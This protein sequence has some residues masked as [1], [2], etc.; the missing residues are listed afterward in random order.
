MRT[1]NHE[2]VWTADGADVGAGQPV[3][4]DLGATAQALI[5]RQRHATINNKYMFTI[6]NFG[7]ELEQDER[8]QRF[9]RVLRPDPASRRAQGHPGSSVLHEGFEGGDWRPGGMQPTY[10]SIDKATG[11]AESPTRAMAVGS[12]SADEYWASTNIPEQDRFRWRPATGSQA[13]ASRWTTR[14]IFSAP[15]RQSP[16]EEVVTATTER[17]VFA[18]P[19]RGRHDLRL[20][21]PSI[22]IHKFN[23]M[24]DWGWFYFITQP[25]GWLIDNDLQN[26]SAISASR[27]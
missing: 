23:L 19:R 13:P 10:T 2:T 11:K 20:P 9:S 3:V 16:P 18:G 5:F 21:S 8:R 17:C 7:H 6:T 24:I 15:K 1:P 22:G 14:P 27:S 4:L 26:T 25:M 12:V